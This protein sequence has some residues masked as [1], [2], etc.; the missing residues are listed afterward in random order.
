MAAG[1]GFAPSGDTVVKAKKAKQ[2]AKMPAEIRKFALKAREHA[3]AEDTITDNGLWLA[4]LTGQGQTKLDPLP[5]HARLLLDALQAKTDPGE[6]DDILSQTFLENFR[7]SG[8]NTKSIAAATNAVEL[9]TVTR[10][11]IDKGR[12]VGLMARLRQS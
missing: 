6:L 2:L 10:N 8:F 7:D 4:S 9:L 5:E 11:E 1:G 3:N 12:M